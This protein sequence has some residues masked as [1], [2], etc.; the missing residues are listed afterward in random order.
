MF[1]KFGLVCL[2]KLCF[3]TL[4]LAIY[5]LIFAQVPRAVIATFKKHDEA[6]NK[7]HTHT[8][9]ENQTFDDV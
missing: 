5:L 6:I 8:Q 7:T 4:S 2:A 9:K 1:F 3:G